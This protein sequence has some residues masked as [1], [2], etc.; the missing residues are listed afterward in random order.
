MANGKH[1]QVT[2]AF[3]GVNVPRVLDAIET[4]KADLELARSRYFE[5]ARLE[6]SKKTSRKKLITKRLDAAGERILRLTRKLAV[7]DLH[8]DLI[9]HSVRNE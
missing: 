5:L 9:H 1:K 3:L 7:L 6:A 8:R 2:L 4:T